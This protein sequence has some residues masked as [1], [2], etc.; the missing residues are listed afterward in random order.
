MGEKC[1]GDCDRQCNEHMY[2]R[3]SL[4][5]VKDKVATLDNTLREFSDMRAKINM[6]GIIAF[7]LVSSIF[8]FISFVYN[9]QQRAVDQYNTDRLADAKQLT[10]MSESISHINKHL[11]AL[12]NKLNSI[13]VKTSDGKTRSVIE[14]SP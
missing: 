1:G 6:V 2:Q 9:S 10:A 7:A 12:D 5:E 8:G 13:M 14:V 3:E 11:T 4:S